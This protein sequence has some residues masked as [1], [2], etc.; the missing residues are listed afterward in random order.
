MIPASPERSRPPAIV[1]PP[2]E[3]QG[4]AATRRA[5][6]EP[7]MSRWPNPAHALRQ[8]AG[9][10]EPRASANQPIAVRPSEYEADRRA[11]HRPEDSDSPSK[12]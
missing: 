8:P 5:A 10:D 2:P 11:G 9:A 7:L 12:K 3:T 6:D 4:H 1:P